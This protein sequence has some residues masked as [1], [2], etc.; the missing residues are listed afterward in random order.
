MTKAHRTGGDVDTYCNK[1]KLSLAH[2]I[3]AMDN[4][5]ILRVTCKTCKNEHAY[6]HEPATATRA[7]AAR[8]AAGTTSRSRAVSP[9][10]LYERAIAG[11]D[12]S[13]GQRYR[14]THSFAEGDVVDHV[15]FGLGLVTRELADAKIEVTFP[16]GTRVLVHSR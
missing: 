3:V 4:S 11:H 6:K 14:I 8:K 2:V 12:L 9:A 13:T 1:C 15:K 10:T 5:R 16:E 7:P